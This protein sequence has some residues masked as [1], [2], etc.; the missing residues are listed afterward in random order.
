MIRLGLRISSPS[1]IGRAVV[2]LLS[3]I[4]PIVPIATAEDLSAAPPN[5]FRNQQKT[6]IVT[7][8]RKN[9]HCVGDLCGCDLTIPNSN[10]VF[11]RLPR[12]IYDALTK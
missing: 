2:F 7:L 4:G 9:C 10:S 5:N 8:D 6:P 12:D 1:T 11:L 3:T